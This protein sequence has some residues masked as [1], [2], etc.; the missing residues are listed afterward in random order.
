MNFLCETI[1]AK[2][3]QNIEDLLLPQYQISKK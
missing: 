3:T 2:A 1:N